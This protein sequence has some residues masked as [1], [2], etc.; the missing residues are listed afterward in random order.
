MTINDVSN[1]KMIYN[2]VLKIVLVRQTRKIFLLL[3]TYFTKIIILLYNIVKK[4]SF[5]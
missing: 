4:T 3:T 5:F 2:D 1:C